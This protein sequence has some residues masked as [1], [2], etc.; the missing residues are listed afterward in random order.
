[1]GMSATGDDGRTVHRRAVF[2]IS[3]FDP[4]GAAYYHRTYRTEAPRQGAT[5]GWHYE[6][7]PREKRA[8][9]VQGWTVNASPSQQGPGQAE[10]VSVDMEFLVWD[11]IVRSQWPKRW[12]GVLVGSVS[13]YWSAISS[14]LA[15]VRV[16]SQSRRTLL[17]LAYP[18]I[19]WLLTSLL[20]VGGGIWLA[21]V[22]GW[23]W[24]AGLAAGVIAVAFRIEQELHTSWLLRIYRFADRWARG[25]LPALDQR[26]DDMARRVAHRLMHGNGEG[27]LDDEVLVVGYS[28]GSM[29]AADVLARVG[30]LCEGSVGAMER[31]SVLTLAQCMPLLGLM[32]AANGYRQVLASARA[33]G[34]TWVDVSAPTDW[35]SFALIDPFAICLGRDGVER[36]QAFV[37]P[38]FHLLFRPADYQLLK[39]DKRRLHLQYLRSA[40]LAGGYDYFQITAGPRTLWGIALQWKNQT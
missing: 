40:P 4:K 14:G 39:N 29:L 8:E 10:A 13:A 12:W 37:S 25:H 5:N 16:W 35:G 9:L 18:A 15:L 38:R 23:A 19:F 3:G 7:G 34:A 20:A 24:G 6:V 11:D 28:V 2:F 31:L 21:R 26:L 27:Q 22:S 17:A 33:A 30:K 36:R 32:P 1:M